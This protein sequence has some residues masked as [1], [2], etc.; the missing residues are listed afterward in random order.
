MPLPEL[1]SAFDAIVTS[2]DAPVKPSPD[3]FRIALSQ[4]S[5]S[6]NEAVVIEDSPNG[7]MAAHR[8]G[9]FCVTVPN[10]IT[11]SLSFEH[12]DLRVES[13]AELTLTQLRTAHREFQEKLF[14]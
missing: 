13:L 4:L 14:L 3:I 7:A 11:R 9:I 1:T 8:A 2:D 10:S 6:A 12:G 5:V